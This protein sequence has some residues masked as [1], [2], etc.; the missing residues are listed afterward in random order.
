MSPA[1]TLQPLA[2][3]LTLPNMFNGLSK[4]KRAPRVEMFKSL[5]G[6]TENFV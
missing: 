5:E 1:T 3:I 4:L 6:K 2:L